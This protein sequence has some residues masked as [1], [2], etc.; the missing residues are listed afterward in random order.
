[1]EPTVH[2]GIGCYTHSETNARGVRIVVTNTG[3]APINQIKL[4]W[5]YEFETP[6]AGSTARVKFQEIGRSYSFVVAIGQ[7]EGP[8]E[9]GQS[10]VFLF[11][12]EL[13]ESMLSVVQSLSPERYSVKITMDG[14]E[15]TGIPGKDWGE[16]IE[17]HFQQS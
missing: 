3:V 14:K 1:M 7:N 12:T 2:L 11:S 9:V 4:E 8:L 5:A 16:F 10:R 15:E 17:R 13:M 6:Q